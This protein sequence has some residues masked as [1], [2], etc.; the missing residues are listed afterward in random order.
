VAD[1]V[2]PTYIGGLGFG[3]KWNMGWMHDTLLYMSKDPVHRKHHHGISLRILYAF[4]ENFILHCPTTRSPTARARC[5][6]DASDRW[7]NSP[8]CAAI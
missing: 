8:I 4:T 5:C 6:Q 7:Q 1:S 3:Y 2:R